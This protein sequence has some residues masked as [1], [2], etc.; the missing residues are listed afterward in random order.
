MDSRDR[1][2]IVERCDGRR[3][4][5]KPL[6]LAAD[7]NFAAT[8]P[9]D[10]LVLISI[11]NARNEGGSARRNPL[12]R[13]QVADY[14]WLIRPTRFNISPPPDFISLIRATCWTRPARVKGS[15]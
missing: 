12:F 15:R 8:G 2:L 13:A 3:P 6:Q 5:G 9:I 14:A 1:V 11:C 7:L 10:P 4:T